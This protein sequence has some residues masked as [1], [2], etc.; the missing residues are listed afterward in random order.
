M[1]A[2]CW[3]AAVIGTLAASG[4]TGCQPA[5]SR[6]EGKVTCQGQPVTDQHVNFFEPALGIGASAPLGSDGT[7]RVD[8]E[9]SPGN[10]EVWLVKPAPPPGGAAPA[11]QD[12]AKTSP[13][14]PARYAQKDTSDLRAKVVAGKNHFEFELHAR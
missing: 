10:Y 4:V 13:R 2:L 14:V 8:G 5:K 3:A 7:F 12:S 9:V 11:P 1:R 6:L